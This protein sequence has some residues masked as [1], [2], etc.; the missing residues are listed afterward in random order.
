MASPEMKQLCT[1][2]SGIL[3][4]LLISGLTDSKSTLGGVLP[5]CASIA[6][7]AY[8]LPRQCGLDRVLEREPC[9]SFAHEVDI[10]LIKYEVLVRSIDS[11]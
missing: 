9:S 5:E 8:R 3:A 4:F 10:S 7:I 6:W 2:L 11:F 1:H